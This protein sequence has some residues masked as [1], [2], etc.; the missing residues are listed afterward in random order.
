MIATVSDSV[1]GGMTS[2]LGGT[3]IQF[4]LFTLCKSQL[5]KY[6]GAG[7][8]ATEECCTSHRAGSLR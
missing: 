5:S 3:R 7:L 8:G 4:L 1:G 2:R 6:S